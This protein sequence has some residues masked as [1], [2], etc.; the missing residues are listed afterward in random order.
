MQALE[1]GKA[2]NACVLVRHIGGVP[3]IETLRTLLSS[4]TEDICSAY[5]ESV[6]RGAKN[7][8]ELKQMLD[9]SLSYAAEDKLFGSFSGWVGPFRCG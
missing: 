6:P 1:T 5:G 8:L 2:H 3:G 7:T 9:R 4:L